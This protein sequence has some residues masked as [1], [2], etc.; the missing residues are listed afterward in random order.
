MSRPLLHMHLRRL[1][2]AGLVESS[3]ELSAE[4]K[5]MN[6]LSVVPFTLLLTP[7]RVA[8]AVVTLTISGGD[9]GSDGGQ[10]EKR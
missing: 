1:Q 8:E 4:G 3:L 7:E 6:Y 2:A 10:E 9:I 5:A